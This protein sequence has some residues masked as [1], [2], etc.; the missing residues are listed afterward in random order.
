MQRR[1]TQTAV[2]TLIKTPSMSDL[3]FTDGKRDKFMNCRIVLLL[4]A[5][6][7]YLTVCD[8]SN[9]VAQ[10]KSKPATESD[11]YKITTFQT[12]ADVVL[13]ASSFQMLPSGKMAVATR[14]GEIWLIANPFAPEVKA[15]QF[16][17][18]AH[19]LHEVLSLTE[20]DGWLY[21]T[22]R[23]DVSRLKDT[24]N[25]GEADLF[26][27]VNDGWEINGDYHEYAFGS[28]F[29][30]DGN[31]W[32]VLCLTG[33]FDSNCKYRGWCV[34]ITPEGKLIPTC[35]GVRSPGGIGTNQ[36]GDMFYTDNQGPWNGTCELKHLI[37]GKFMGHPGGF[38][39]Y[40]IAAEFMGKAPKEPLSG[41][42]FMT[43][44]T[45]H[46]QSCSRT[47][48]WDIPPVASPVTRQA[49]NLDRSPDRCLW[50]TSPTARSCGVT[51]KRLTV[52]I[53]VSASRSA[54]DS[55]RVLWVW[56]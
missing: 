18:F 37:P 17:R 9:V 12:P 30:K 26:E 43:E 29:D 44:A 11:F 39:W 56:K 49:A 22:Q 42:R 16:K 23:C 45:S 46:R 5:T 25:D 36:A 19:G 41:S 20:R 8:F 10:E 52:T 3:K 53:K 35:S 1:L 50:G 14:R 21:I 15:E 34:R 32:V 48:K 51:W 31:I 54:K 2:L 28:K 7:T 4:I 24:D 13:E 40:D 33:S 27:V 6:F 55:G 47:R 38:K